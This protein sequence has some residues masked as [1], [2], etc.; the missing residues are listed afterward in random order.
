VTERIRIVHVID[1]LGR[2]GAETLLVGLLPRLAERY[3]VSLVTL[4]PEMDFPREA[5]VCSEFHCLGYRGYASL[6]RCAL[7]LRRIV[8]RHRPALVRSQLFLSSLVARIATPRE[9]PLVFS[10]HNPM[11]Q[12]CYEKN[13]LALPLERLTYRP[14][15]ALIGVSEGALADF[16]AWVGIKGRSYVLHNAIDDRFFDVSRPRMAAGRPLRMVAVGNLKEQKNYFCLLDAFRQLRDIDVALDIYGE[17][18]LR[19]PLQQAIDRDGLRIRLMGKHADIPA[20]LSGYDLYVMPSL[21]EGFGIAA[22]EAMAA[23]LPMLLSDLSVLR[24]ITHGNALFFDPRAPEALARLIREIAAKDEDLG[25]LSR[26]GIAIADSHYRRDAYLAKL[27]RIYEEVMADGRR[28][29]AVRQS[30]EV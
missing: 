8:R 24:E 30:A 25:A 22:A 15:H 23:G 13:R 12:D 26:R 27:D 29:S 1:S 7:A 11:S 28:G 6:P 21:Y 17:G 20:A 3:D 2:G 5:L 18:H 4:T 19:A 10:I 16:D 9:V 14:R